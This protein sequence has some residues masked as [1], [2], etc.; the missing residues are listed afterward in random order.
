VQRE[1]E[2]REPPVEA[3]GDHGLGQDE[4][5]QEQENDGV[6]EDDVAKGVRW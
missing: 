6:G 4:G 2:E 3:V 5:P 1:N